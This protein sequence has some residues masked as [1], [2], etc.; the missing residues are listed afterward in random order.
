M[1]E[2]HLEND[3][4]VFGLQVKTFPLGI[5][6]AFDSLIGRL[7]GGLNRAYYGISYITDKGVVYLAVTA[8]RFEG[9]SAKYP[10]D[11]FRIAKGNYRTVIVKDWS[12]KTDQIKDVFHTMMKDQ[13][14]DEHRPCVEW[15]KDDK[16]MM[17]MVRIDES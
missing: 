12:T 8:E 7:P 9:E 5:G 1:E 15:Y 4:K 14:P 2:Y 13:C 10:Y 16:E 3:L 11:S 6:E 17:C